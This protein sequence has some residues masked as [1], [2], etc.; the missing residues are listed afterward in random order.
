LAVASVIKTNK[1]RPKCKKIPFSTKKF[2]KPLLNTFLP[3]GAA[4]G[5]AKQTVGKQRVNGGAKLFLLWR[6]SRVVGITG[7][8]GGVYFVAVPATAKP[9]YG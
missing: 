8:W 5:P 3:A 1:S 6:V 9:A 2:Q 4:E 7:D